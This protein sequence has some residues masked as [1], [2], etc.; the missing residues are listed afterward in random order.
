MTRIATAM[1]SAGYGTECCQVYSIARR[2][3]FNEALKNIGF[4]T[5]SIDDVQR[6]QWELLEVEIAAWIKVIKIC[7]TVLLPGERKLCDTVFTENPSNSVILFSNLVRSVV[8]QLLTFA[9]AVV[10]TNQISSP[11]R[12]ATAVATAEEDD[13]HVAANFS[14]LW[15]LH[16]ISRREHGE[17]A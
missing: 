11:A 14:S 1:I 2:N 12:G 8:I 17:S 7:T 15:T 4:D 13:E 10:L 16:L 9:D 6:M 5:I 3:A